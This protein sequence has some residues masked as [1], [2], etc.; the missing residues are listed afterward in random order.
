[1]YSE[2]LVIMAGDR[3]RDRVATHVR[4]RRP[5]DWRIDL[6]HYLCTFLRKPAA[7]G[8]S[9]ALQQVHPD[10]ASLFHDHFVDTP[11]TF[12]EM[13]VF[14]RDKGMTFRDILSASERLR[15]RGLRRLSADQ[16]QAE[17]ISGPR[18]T[19]LPSDDT[20]AADP[21][22]AAIEDPASVTLDMLSS[23]LDIRYR[24]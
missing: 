9:V 6:M 16:I 20:P 15:Q 14:T 21:H 12:V 10:V 17:M 3:K 19:A 8:R 24:I 23:L 1:M 18:N 5:G 4:S 7:L 13:L 11:R 2:R 22:Q